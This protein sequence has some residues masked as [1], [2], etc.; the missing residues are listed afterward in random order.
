MKDRKMGTIPRQIIFS[1]FLL[2]QVPR[3]T[4]NLT[5]IR[6]IS[7]A[8][9]PVLPYLQV[10]DS[11]LS[12]VPQPKSSVRL[13]GD[14]PSYGPDAEGSCAVYTSG[15]I[16]APTGETENVNCSGNCSVMQDGITET[17]LSAISGTNISENKLQVGTSIRTGSQ[18]IALKSAGLLHNQMLTMLP[19]NRSRNAVIQCFRNKCSST[20]KHNQTGARQ[21]NIPSFCDQNLITDEEKTQLNDISHEDGTS[22][23][24]N[25]EK[26]EELV[27]PDP[28][29]CCGSG[30]VNCVYIK[31]VQDV[32]KRDPND[33]EKVKEILDEIEDFNVRMF[34][35]LELGL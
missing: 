8:R 3:N 5:M 32:L 25:A 1:C 4:I 18:V 7:G 27:P 29:T 35:K 17:K 15:N 14:K 11:A 24:S 26:D 30:C 21:E 19:T 33:R 28:E 13:T 22:N 31:Y 9:R 12:T 10:Q 20:H 2:V 16:S 6:F 34:L 23:D